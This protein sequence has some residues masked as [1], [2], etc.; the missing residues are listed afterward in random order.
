MKIKNL[1]L[2]FV[3]VASFVISF[4]SCEK[5]EDIVASEYVGYWNT[6]ETMMIGDFEMTIKNTLHLTETGFDMLSQMEQGTTLFKLAGDLSANETAITITPT[7]IS[8]PNEETGALE[9]INKGDAN[10][11]AA[12]TEMEMLE[13]ETATYT[14]DGNTLTLTFEGDDPVVFTKQ[15]D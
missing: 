4:T 5:E 14:V 7:M 6:I 2:S 9:D 8:L 10:W 13:S 12:M 3:L 1:L 15:L 11:D